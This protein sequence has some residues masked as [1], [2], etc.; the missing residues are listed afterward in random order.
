MTENK[1]KKNSEVSW[2]E[3]VM[4]MFD[5]SELSEGKYPNVA[6]LRRVAKKVIGEVLKSGTTN[7]TIGPDNYCA[8]IYE[9]TFTKSDGSLVTYGDAADSFSGNTNS[10][11]D[12]Y[13]AAM[14]STRAEARALRK[15][16]GIKAVSA[17]EMSGQEAAKTY[18]ES[19]KKPKVVRGDEDTSG[20]MISTNQI[21]TINSLCQKLKLSLSDFVKEEIG[22]EITDESDALEKISFSDG[23]FLTQLL[24]KMQT[25]I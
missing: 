14:A 3:Y 7:L 9:I 2:D 6:G 5:K 18:A 10:P 22:V 4:G 24:S 19:K 8:A 23:K 25:T 12:A 20:R 15:A 13:P 17:E 16:L 1:N 11:F 21:K